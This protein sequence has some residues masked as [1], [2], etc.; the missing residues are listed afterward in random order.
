M[1]SFDL[2]GALASEHFSHRSLVYPNY[3]NEAGKVCDFLSKPKDSQ[4]R[5]HCCPM[6]QSYQEYCFN[7][8]Y[9]LLLE[10]SFASLFVRTIP[11]T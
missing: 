5:I 3:S 2:S 9:Q 10:I 1:A 6:I 8:F 7:R 11:I 4:L